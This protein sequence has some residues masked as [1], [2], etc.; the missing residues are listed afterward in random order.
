[1][2]LFNRNTNI[3]KKSC[4]TPKTVETTWISPF[5]ILKKSLFHYS[6]KS[7]DFCAKYIKSILCEKIFYYQLLPTLSLLEIWIKYTNLYTIPCISIT[8]PHGE[9]FCAVVQ[10]MVE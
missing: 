2:E 5:S 3:S 8:N 1:M 7:P 10:D 4:N 6:A 9:F